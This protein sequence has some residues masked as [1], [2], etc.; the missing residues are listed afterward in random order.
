MLEA[1]A[2]RSQQRPRPGFWLRDQS[3][4]G[5]SKSLQFKNIIAYALQYDSGSLHCDVQL[6]VGLPAGQ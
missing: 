3:D 5:T 6:P 4:L 2:E 1:E